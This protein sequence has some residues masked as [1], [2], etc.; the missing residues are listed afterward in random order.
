MNILLVHPEGNLNYNANLL[1]LIDLL[2]EAGHRV[3]YV[4]P[5]RRGLRQDAPARHTD[6]VLLEHREA[7]G[8]F[9][10][11]A[12]VW[13]LSRPRAADFASWQGYDLVLA[14]DRGVIEGAS[15]AR[16]Y[17]IPHALISYE[18]FFREETSTRY[19]APEIDACRDV[20]FAI[21]QDDVRARHLSRQNGIPPERV[22]RIPNAAR[23][24]RAALPKPRVLHERFGLAARMK[25]ALHIGSFAE[26]THAPFLLKSTREWPEDWVL[27][28]HERYG[29]SAA[30]LKLIRKH[31]DPQRVRRSE[32]AFATP[33]EMSAFVQ[34]ADLGLA[35]YR[36]DYA[37]P[38]IG[39]NIEDIGLSSGKI[40]TYLQHG[41]PVATHELGEI[42][43]LIRTYGA[44][45]VFPLDRPF[46]PREPPA[47]SA[48][49]CRKL[50]E[51]HLDLDVF[52]KNL[53]DAVAAAGSRIAS[54]ARAGA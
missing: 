51:R 44:G 46:V 49:A 16:H 20:A 18:I 30:L 31:A 33:A 54:V 32:A 12:G 21:C 10:F 23:G 11:P 14:V 15:I 37:N 24:F 8:R 17:G 53:V 40:A 26:W 29:S 2:G 25:A 52:G 9:M 39:R 34:S 38:W 6:V 1:G 50:F 45:E 28:I 42:A 47:G 7:E 4:A 35:L 13:G 27:V 3:T 41:I 5:R 48:A 19:K 22:L 43:E 36:P